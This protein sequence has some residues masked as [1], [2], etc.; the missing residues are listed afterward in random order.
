M[1]G[2]DEECT[3]AG[4]LGLLLLVLKCFFFQLKSL[5]YLLY[6]TGGPRAS[7]RSVTAIWVYVDTPHCADQELLPLCSNLPFF[8]ALVRS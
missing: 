5:L 1:R 4:I 7:V 8:I 2:T 3:A 6:P